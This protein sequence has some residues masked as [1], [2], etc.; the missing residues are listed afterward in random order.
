M[1]S[2]DQLMT[3]EEVSAHLQVPV[4]TLYNWRYLGTGP[5][6]AK[7]GRHLRYRRA[8]VEAWVDERVKLNASEHGW[9]R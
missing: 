1:Q 6:C 9:G 8:D 4:T 7:I 3:V 5:A 2:E